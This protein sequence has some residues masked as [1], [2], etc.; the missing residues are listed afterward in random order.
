[1]NAPRVLVVDD[2][3]Y[4]RARVTEQLQAS[5]FDVVA[6]AR[7]GTEA[8]Q[9]NLDALPDIVVL[10]LQMAA[11]SGLDAL[12]GFRATRPVPTLLFASLEGVGAELAVEAL[13]EGASEVVP[14]SAGSDFLPHL[15]E[16]AHALL[17]AHAVRSTAKGRYVT[18]GNAA[19][20]RRTKP[21]AIVIAGSTGAPPI[22]D[23]FARN[24]PADCDVP[25]LIVQ[26]MP[27]GFT[28]TFAERLDHVCALRVQHGADGM[29]VGP[30]DV[31][32]LPAGA[33]TTV[34]SAQGTSITLRTSVVPAPRMALPSISALLLSA[35]SA[36]GGQVT[37]LILTGMGQ[38]GANAVPSLLAGGGTVLAQD[39]QEA[40]IDSM[41]T[42]AI[43]AGAVPC[44]ASQMFARMG[45]GGLVRV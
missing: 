8:I 19:R 11:G 39:P 4:V 41:P 27:P 12:R 33:V 23:A 25:V 22:M 13:L 1:M 17:K 45:L 3:Q 29:S 44:P 31:A 20:R 40:F 30:G 36:L 7:G 2:S 15:A 42:A 35:G 9:S 26:H 43:R 21:R 18:R 32:V 28:K 14:K 6:E 37:A 16:R 34:A 38:D 5:G 24:L 10:D